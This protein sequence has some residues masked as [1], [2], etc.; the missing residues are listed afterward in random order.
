MPHDIVMNVRFLRKSQI[1]RGSNNLRGR[2]NSNN[3]R[4]TRY[5]GGVD[6]LRGGDP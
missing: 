4:V 1:F 2:G 6:N 3:C 5:Q